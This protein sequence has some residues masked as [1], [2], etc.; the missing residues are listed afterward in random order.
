[1]P[2]ITI[3][4]LPSD[5]PQTILQKIE[6]EITKAVVGMEVLEIDESH[7]A[8]RFQPDMRNLM[9]G[10]DIFVD[11]VLFD[12]PVRTPEVRTEFAERIEGVIHKFFPDSWVE[13]LSW[14][15]DRSWGFALQKPLERIGMMA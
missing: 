8:F 7:M 6:E 9:V 1:M 5:T 13:V 4:G 15:F 2:I 11:A 10:S 12:E 14:P 3:T